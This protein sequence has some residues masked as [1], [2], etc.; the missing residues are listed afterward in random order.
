MATETKLN[1]KRKSHVVIDGPDRA[2]ARP[3]LRASGSTFPPLQVN[4][5]S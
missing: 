3:M 5:F 1:P 2:P 4:A